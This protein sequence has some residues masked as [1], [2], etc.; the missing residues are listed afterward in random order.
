MRRETGTPPAQA[1]VLVLGARVSGAGLSKTLRCRVQAAADYLRG[2]PAAACITTG[3]QG[4]DEPCSEGEAAKRALEALGIEPGRITAETRSRTTLENLR[5]SKA[6]LAEMGCGPA[7]VIATQ[8]YHMRRACMM[9]RHIGLLPHPLYA[10]SNPRALPKNL[11]REALATLKFL[12][13][14]RKG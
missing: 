1:V 5:F 10:E 7:V 13:F 4:R 12:L 6:I 3:G 8:G 2:H 14:Y 9:A 11:C